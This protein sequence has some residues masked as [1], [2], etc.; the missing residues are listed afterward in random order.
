MKPTKGSY[1]YYRP[2]GLFDE[3]LV[4]ECLDTDEP[5]EIALMEH[6]RD[7]GSSIRAV[8]YSAIVKERVEEEEGDKWWHW[9]IFISAA[10]CLIVGFCKVT[11]FLLK[12]IL[13]LFF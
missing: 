4:G 3:V 11:E 1:Y 6:S 7:M 13:N 2:F 8:P 5:N 12:Q 9:V 10:I